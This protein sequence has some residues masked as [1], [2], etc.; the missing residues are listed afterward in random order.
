MQN[1]LNLL[2]QFFFF[3][4]YVSLMSFKSISFKIFLF[5]F[6]SSVGVY[7][8]NGVYEIIVVV[9]EWWILN[10]LNILMNHIIHCINVSHIL[11]HSN[12]I[13][14]FYQKAVL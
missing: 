9:V 1:S 5:D 8:N 7:V 4:E 6:S 12:A 14:F 13:F 11:S 2:F 3:Y 10:K